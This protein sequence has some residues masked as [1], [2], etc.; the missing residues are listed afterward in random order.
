MLSTD[1]LHLLEPLDTAAPQAAHMFHEL[2]KL[3]YK[4]A[5]GWVVRPPAA[6]D[7]TIYG[8]YMREAGATGRTEAAIARL[9][10]WR[11]E[12]NVMWVSELFRT[13]GITL[14]DRFTT[15]L[16][17][18]EQWCEPDAIRLCDI[19]FGRGRGLGALPL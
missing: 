6:G 2:R 4:A 3:G 18:R 13:D 11:R 19:A 1:E 8:A 7:E 10:R 9:Q 5:V 15:N 12:H 16:A 17:A 14:R